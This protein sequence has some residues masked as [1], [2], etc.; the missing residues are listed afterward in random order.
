LL[1]PLEPVDRRTLAEIYQRSAKIEFLDGE[2]VGALGLLRKA[3]GTFSELGDQN[4]EARVLVEFAS[5]YVARGMLAEGECCGESALAKLNEDEYWNRF[6]AHQVLAVCLKPRSPEASLAQLDSAKALLE[7]SPR[8]AM[9]RFIWL[10]VKIKADLL[11]KAEV[12]AALEAAA[13]FFIETE[14]VLNAALAALEFARCWPER[15]SKGLREIAFALAKNV[16]GKL[17]ATAVMEVYRAAAAGADTETVLDAATRKINE[18]ISSAA[19][20]KP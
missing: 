6:T 13:W 5:S 20:T 2:F 3:A 11:P 4:S 17:A 18:A 15:A 12:A 1:T 10:E 9:I 14:E 8:G 19:P 16:G 7:H